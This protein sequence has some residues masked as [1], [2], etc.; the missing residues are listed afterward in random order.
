[1]NASIL[2]TAN[3]IHSE[4]IFT[5]LPQAQSLGWVSE[6][7][8]CFMLALGILTAIAQSSALIFLLSL[9]NVMRQR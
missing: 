1:M 6:L 8:E 4:V 7:Q 2:L 9:F 3:S 5:Q